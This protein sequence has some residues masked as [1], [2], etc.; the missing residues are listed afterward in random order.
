MSG[1]KISQEQ[2]ALLTEY[3]REE[4]PVLSSIQPM[5]R[6]VPQGQLPLSFAQQRLWFLDQL[7]SDSPAYN[8]T[9][10]Y[11]IKGEVNIEVLERSVN[12]IIR[13]HEILR[14]TFQTIDG[15]PL[16]VIAPELTLKLTVEAFEER[17]DELQQQ[18]MVEAREPFHLAQGPLL[19]TRLLRLSTYEHVLLLTVHHIIFD[20]WSMSILYREL[21]ALY[22]TYLQGMPSPLPPLP[23]QYTDFA[24][25]QREW[26]QGEVLNSELDYWKQQLSGAPPV[27]ELPGDRPRPAVQTYRGGTYSFSFPK[28]LSQ[29]LKALSRQEDCTLFQTLLTAFQI[30]LHRYTGQQDILVGSPIA[31]RSHLEIEELIGFFANTLVMRGDLSGNPSFYELL[32]RIRAITLD[33]YDH[34]YLPFEKLV[35]ELHLRR[36]LSYAPLTQVLFVLQNPS[37]SAKLKLANLA[38]SPLEINNGTTKVDFSLELIDAEDGLKGSIQ[39]SVDLFDAE[40]I[41]RMA[42][43]FQTLLEGIVTS[44]QRC[45]SD[46]PL[47]PATEYQQLMEWN[48]PGE[49]QGMEC[50]HTLFE[51]QVQRAPQ[52]VAVIYAGEAFTY[53]EINSRANQLAHY[54]RLQGIGPESLV[55]ICLERSPEMVIALIAVLKAGGI[56]V[57][58]DPDYPQERLLFLVQDAQVALLLTQEPFLSRL[59]MADVP[60]LCLDTDMSLF[61]QQPGYNPCALS[62]SEQVAYLI[63]T[64]G[65]TGVPKGVLLRQSSLVN[66]VQWGQQ[67]YPLTAQDRVLQEASFSFDFAIWQLFGPLTVG[68]QVILPQAG[69]Q[70]DIEYLLSLIVEHRITVLHLIPSLLRVFLEQAKQGHCESVRHVYG[71][72]EPL[73]LDLWQRFCQQMKAQ[74]H[75]V[76]GPTEGSIDSTCWTGKRGE[77]EQVLIGRPIRNVQVY[78]LDPHQQLVPIGVAGEIYIGGAGLAQGYH[79][80]AEVTAERFVPHPFSQEAGQRLYR[81]GDVGCYRPDGNLEY[82]GRV[83]DQVKVR[84]FRIELGEIEMVLKSHP[85]IRDATVMGREERVGEKRLVAYLVGMGGVPPRI[86]EV[87]NFLQKKLP[88]YMV[89]AHFLF[90]ES[91]PLMPNGKLDR[92]A[93]PAPGV[94]QVIEERELIVPRGPLD[95]ILLSLWKELLEQAHISI[96]DDFFELGG[97]SLIVIQLVARLRVAFRVKVMPQDLMDVATTIAE[98]SDLIM[99]RLVEHM[100]NVASEQLFAILEPLSEAEA[101][102]ALLENELIQTM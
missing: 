36:D 80:R 55:G 73:P 79:K 28:T 65:S 51:A 85:E 40:T 63:Y 15:Q 53:Q 32:D 57:P 1:A 13:R 74:F 94:D 52:E 102:T 24:H 66:R 34:Q 8:I 101:W 82:I 84:G 12:E 87:R 5:V 50:L 91:L 30:L 25:W 20:G 78:L 72:A 21:S 99:S 39:Y 7:Q 54:L 45:I 11:R 59:P 29:A 41:A 56:C 2:L 92:K 23:I 95:R 68:A 9:I 67:V 22:A 70:R 17:E 69:G 83:D 98:L 4:G 43:H 37:E 27:L 42:G 71:G 44:P 64:S 97:D 96:C 62:T 60:C 26:L 16:Q 76:Y 19:R 48:A 75:N 47:L 90:L 89:P 58:L 81:T 31:N 77:E 10:G 35:D 61:T 6:E 88:D 33:A 14:T 46:L 86:G 93:L 49:P 18:A 38:V 100:G 3:M